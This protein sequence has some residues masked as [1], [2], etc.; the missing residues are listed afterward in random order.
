MKAL[1]HSLALASLMALLPITSRA[2]SQGIDSP[3]PGARPA[4]APDCVP[5]V[6][7]RDGENLAL[8]LRKPEGGLQPERPFLIWAIGST[9][10]SPER[11]EPET[12]GNT[13]RAAP[14]RS[15]SNRISGAARNATRMEN[16]SRS[17]LIAR[18]SGK[19]ASGAM[20]RRPSASA[21][22]RRSKTGSTLL[23]SFPAK[24]AILPSS[25]SRLSR[26]P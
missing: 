6:N 9:A 12:R 5:Q 1:P 26:R 16:P 23:N 14:A 4:G 2:Q 7:P 10:A 22:P 21:L 18:L 13:S 11:T 3:A 8:T 20:K 15:S 25:F 24:T 19:S 17:T